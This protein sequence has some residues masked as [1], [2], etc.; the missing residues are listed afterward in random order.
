[1]KWLA[2]AVI[3]FAQQP[4]KVPE[5][6][7]TIDTEIAR[8]SQQSDRRTGSE[9]PVRPAPSPLTDSQRPSEL[10]AGTDRASDDADIQGKL[11]TFTKLL[12]VVGFLQF[13]ALVG[14]VVI[15]CRQAK[16]MGRQAHE[17]KRQRGYMRLQWRAMGTQA[18]HME[19]Q[20]TEMQESRKIA[21]KT[22]VLQYR[23]KVIA[24]YAK[25]YDFNVAELGEPAKGKVRF[26]V[27]NIGGSPARIIGG[28][29]AL[30][31]AEGPRS[32]HSNRAEIYK[33]TDAPMQEFTLQPGEERVWEEI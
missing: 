26:K 25:A 21:N 12:V 19:G 8:F 28:N 22:L 16:I 9:Q 4:A 6:K 5:A 13:F 23:P 29:V 32:P 2:I 14:Q 24:R 10:K 30:W 20:L 27:V 18:E 33:G 31:S 17:M 11:V 3:I 7:R 1:M 15:Y